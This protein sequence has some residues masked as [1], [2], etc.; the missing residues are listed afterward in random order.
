MK[1]IP[2]WRAVALYSISMWCFYLSVLCLVLPEILFLAIGYDVASPRLWW[3]FGLLFA[4]GG[5]FGRL[6]KQ[7]GV[8]Q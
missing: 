5:G 1:L 3:G 7:R 2:N 6:I 4:L 8:S